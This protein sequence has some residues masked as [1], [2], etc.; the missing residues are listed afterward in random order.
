MKPDPTHLQAWR[1]QD[2]DLT[3]RL[4]ERTTL[5]KVF[6]MLARSNSNGP[7]LTWYESG[8]RS[9]HLKYDELVRQ[10][11][12]MASW[13]SS[14]CG[15]RRGDRVVVISGDCPEA[16]IA[17]LAVMSIGAITVPVNNS[18]SERVLK[19]VVDQVAP[20]VVLLGRRVHRSLQ[21]A[22]GCD[23]VRLPSLPLA[24]A[25]NLSSWPCDEVLPDDPAVILFTSGTTSAPKGV[26]LSH[27]N[28]LINAEGLSQ[29]HNLAVHRNHMCI[30]P[31]FH[32]NAFGY[33]MVRLSLFRQSN[34]AV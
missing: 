23:M 16:L 17:H 4:I 21:A 3:L 1:Y 29:V 11:M 20:R 15:V 32:A 34:R 12:L 24:E 2:K 14:G 27:Y 25:G 26:C 18:E 10:V 13:L 33:S 6:E 5:P 9:L 8:T 22:Y 31:L 28:L 19:L 7:A 30:L